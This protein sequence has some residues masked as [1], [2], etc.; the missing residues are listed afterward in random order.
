MC[1]MNNFVLVEA[2]RRYTDYLADLIAPQIYHGINS[3]YRTA[4]ATAN[5]S[6]RGKNVLVIFQKMLSNIPHWTQSRIDTETERIRGA[7]GAASFLDKMIREITSINI[8][9]MTGASTTESVIAEEFLKQFKLET[10]IHRCYIECGFHAYKN[11]YMYLC[12]EFSD[13]VMESHRNVTIVNE[14]IHSRIPKVL[15]SIL[16][17]NSMIKELAVNAT[18]SEAVDVQVEF[19]EPVHRDNSAQLRQQIS[20]MIKNDS[21]QKEHRKIEDI[22]DLSARLQQYRAPTVK[23]TRTKTDRPSTRGPM[24]IEL[25]SVGTKS[26]IPPGPEPD[27]ADASVVEFYNLD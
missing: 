4:V 19:R 23:S 14:V 9:I 26:Y 8:M 13:S 24:E 5:E 15:I 12:P 25:E 21:I 20:E 10:F 6:G 22:L 2:N 17:L 7:S 1:I 18:R 11:S 3:I 27:L 16:P